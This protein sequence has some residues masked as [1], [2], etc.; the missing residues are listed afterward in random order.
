LSHGFFIMKMTRLEKS[1]VNRQKKSERNIQIL[2]S[3]LKLIDPAKIK[4]IL[5]L[6]CGIGFVSAYLA[7]KYNFTI[8]GTD[9]DVEQ[10]KIAKN[11]QPKFDH[12]HFQVEDATKLSFADSSIDLVLSQNVFHHIPNW[13][14]AIKEIN[15]VLCPGGYFLWLDLTFPKLIRNVF[16]PFVKNYGLY[17]IDD[18]R[19]AVDNLGFRLLFQERV[20]H[21]P[22]SQHHLVMQCT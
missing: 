17:T 19:A 1:F 2:E 14:N 22:F 5:E 7:E 10:I 4:T 20:A 3:G 15:R 9:Y 21:G 12:L 13:E 11:L 16:F 18:I 6:G 8:Y